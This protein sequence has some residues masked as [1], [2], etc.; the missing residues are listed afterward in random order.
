MVEGQRAFAEAVKKFGVDK[1]LSSMDETTFWFLYKWFKET[2]EHDF[3]R[4]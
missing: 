1:V 4:C 2:F 3:K